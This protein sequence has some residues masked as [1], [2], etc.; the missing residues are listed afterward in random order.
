MNYLSFHELR[1][2][3]RIGQALLREAAVPAYAPHQI[4]LRLTM[5]A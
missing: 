4:V 2:L 3:L 1:K 5:S